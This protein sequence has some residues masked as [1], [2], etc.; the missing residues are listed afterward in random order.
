M[1]MGLRELLNSLV[2][3]FQLLNASKE[4]VFLMAQL[5]RGIEVSL[6]MPKELLH[7]LMIQTLAMATQESV[8]EGNNPSDTSRRIRP[9]TYSRA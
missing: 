9:I 2:V 1:Y 6:L 3:A 8:K 4:V 5:C 7:F